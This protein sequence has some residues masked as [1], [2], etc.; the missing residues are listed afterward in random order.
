MH[1]DRLSRNFHG[2][3]S[4]RSRLLPLESITFVT[5]RRRSRSFAISR[6]RRENYNRRKWQLGSAGIFNS[7]EFR[8]LSSK[9][10][11]RNIGRSKK[12]RLS[13]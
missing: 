9:L 3:C 10:S 4:S 13:N 8:D 1:V 5:A 11:R 7:V 12:L 2:K 6:R